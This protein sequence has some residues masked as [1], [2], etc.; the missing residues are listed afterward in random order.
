[1]DARKR[2]AVCLSCMLLMAAECTSPAL[3]ANRARVMQEAND[4]RQQLAKQ[5]AAAAQLRAAKDAAEA[6]ADEARRQLAASQQA[7]QAQSNQQAE[8]FEALRL[9]VGS[10]LLPPSAPCSCIMWLAWEQP[11]ASP[12]GKDGSLVLW[13]SPF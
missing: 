9:K 1:M 6:A 5:E 4:V 8:E 10:L 11:P 13:L 7:Q 3:S 2:N 12:V